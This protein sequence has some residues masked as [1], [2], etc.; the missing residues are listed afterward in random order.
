[1]SITVTIVGT[2]LIGGSMAISLIDSVFS[3]KVIVVEA[4]EPH[5]KK[6]I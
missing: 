1:M 5:A 2:G 6:A 4:N 3:G